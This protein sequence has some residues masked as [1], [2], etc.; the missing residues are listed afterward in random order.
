[1]NMERPKP[2]AESKK[3]IIELDLEI[4]KKV[5]LEASKYLMGR[6]S[7]DK[8]HTEATVDWLKQLIQAEGG[9]ERILVPAAWLHDIGYNLSEIKSL[10]YDGVLKIKEQHAQLGAD[11]ARK[12]LSELGDFTAEEIEEISR[13]ILIHDELEQLSEKANDNVIR[14]VEADSLG[15]IDDRVNPKYSNFSQADIQRFLETEFLPQRLPLFRS[16]LAK[17]KAGELSEKLKKAYEIE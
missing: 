8:P 17:Q 11:E 15:M 14:L 6:G 12:I 4:E 13:L 1:M 3:E 2:E 16:E 7:W 5:Q 9:N 10:D